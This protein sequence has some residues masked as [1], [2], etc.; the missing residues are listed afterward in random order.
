MP[1]LLATHATLLE[2][3]RRSMNLIGPGPVADHFTDSERALGDLRPEGR[4]VDL[5]SGA[6]FPGIPLLARGE[7]HTVDLVDSRQKRCTFLQMVLEEAEVPRP[8][9]RVLCQRVEA[10]E[11]PYD[12]VVS[13]AF[14]PPPDAMAHAER[15]LRPGGRCVLFLQAGAKPPERPGWSVVAT[16]PYEV[17]G[18]QR[19]GV[20]LTWSP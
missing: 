5:G 8:R 20:H 16:H 7:Q 1:D 18:R 3:F 2:R 14:A 11:G 9:W 17:G 6:G 10:L 15:L 12:G 13:R 4:W 19:K